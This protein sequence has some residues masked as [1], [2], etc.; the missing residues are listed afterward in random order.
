MPSRMAVK[1]TERSKLCW[2]PIIGDNAYVV[3]NFFNISLVLTFS[4]IP[5]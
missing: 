3:T 4:C 2:L 5:G 1:M